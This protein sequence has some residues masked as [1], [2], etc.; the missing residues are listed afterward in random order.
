MARCRGDT[1]VITEITLSCLAQHRCD[2]D[3]QQ[4]SAHQL[5][6]SL[7]RM[8]RCRPIV[9]TDQCLAQHRSILCSS[10]MSKLGHQQYFVNTAVVK[11]VHTYSYTVIN[12]INGGQC[13]YFSIQLKIYA[14]LYYIL[15]ILF[16]KLIMLK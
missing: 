1:I 11:V 6:S 3:H 9:I 16:M 12:L 4:Y 10:I 8:A 13:F 14:S 5:W 15:Q 7:R 2:L